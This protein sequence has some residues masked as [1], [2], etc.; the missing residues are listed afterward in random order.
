MA[1]TT[2]QIERARQLLDGGDSQAEVAG[3]MGITRNQVGQIV[4]D[5]IKAKPSKPA[6]PVRATHRKV[7]A[8][9][10]DYARD[11]LIVGMTASGASVEDIAEQI[12]ADPAWTAARVAELYA[13]IRNG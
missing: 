6:K 12:G 1:W 5:H 10:G 3:K 11:L 13:G 2:E 4:R 8:K 7:I 9:G